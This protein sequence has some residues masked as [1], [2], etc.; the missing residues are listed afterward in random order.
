MQKL[1]QKGSII[2][3]NKSG[4][5]VAFYNLTERKGVQMTFRVTTE[6]TTQQNAAMLALLT[7]FATC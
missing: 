5:N 7:G 4:E 1:K 6:S 3:C 2:R